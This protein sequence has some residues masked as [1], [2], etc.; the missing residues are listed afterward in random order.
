MSTLV[1]VDWDFLVYDGSLCGKHE[2]PN[3]DV[4]D[5]TYLFDWGHSEGH[6]P[7]LGELLWKVR[8][9]QMKRLGYNPL[10]LHAPVPGVSTALEHELHR[11]L[12]RRKPQTYIADSHAN[13]VSTILDHE[14]QHVVSFDQHHDLGYTKTSV[15]AASAGRVDAGSWLWWALTEGPVQ[16][17]TIVYPDWLGMRE[18][19]NQFTDDAPWLQSLHEREV[20]Q[21]MTMSEWEARKEAHKVES[22]FMCRSSNWTAPW[23]DEHFERFSTVAG[24]PTCLDCLA[25]M[26]GRKIGAYDACRPRDFTR[27]YY[28]EFADSETRAVNRL[29]E[30]GAV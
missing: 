27:K 6:G 11:L 12:G 15:L 21:V 5:G 19:E 17:A 26:Q 23:N 24:T 2:S 9:S 8:Y 28:D 22:V 4:M 1:S 30:K 7:V 20:I 13:I 16:S 3:G 14:P 18:W 29:I 10:L 25:D